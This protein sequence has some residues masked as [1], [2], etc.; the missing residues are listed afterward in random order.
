MKTRAAAQVICGA[1]NSTSVVAANA[2]SRK[3]RPARA[4]RCRHKKIPRA[5]PHSAI[6]RQENLHP[7]GA[8]DGKDTEAARRCPFALLGVPRAK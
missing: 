3:P 6:R 4:G 2:L 8:A 1:R 5:R 7:L